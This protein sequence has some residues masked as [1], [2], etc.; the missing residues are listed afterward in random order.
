MYFDC[1][2]DYNQ[3]ENKNKECTVKG[4]MLSLYFWIPVFLNIQIVT[5]AFTPNQTMSKTMETTNKIRM[6]FM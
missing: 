6:N 3:N 1:H 5:L 4:G 2:Q